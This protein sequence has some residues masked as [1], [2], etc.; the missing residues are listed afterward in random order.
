MIRSSLDTSTFFALIFGLGTFALFAQKAVNLV[1]V[2]RSTRNTKQRT[3]IKSSMIP[4]T[5]N[6][7][8]ERLWKFLTFIITS[9]H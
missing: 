9:A 7:F 2:P 3:V 6:G 5:G 1:P 8:E 4:D